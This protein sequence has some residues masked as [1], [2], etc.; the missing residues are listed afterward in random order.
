MISD[1]IGKDE[2]SSAFVYGVYGLF[3]KIANGIILF[4]LVQEFSKGK[5]ELAL[6]LIMGV[7]PLV[8]SISAF[9]LSILGTSLYSQRLA[10]LSMYPTKNKNMNGISINRMGNE[11]D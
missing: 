3:D 9:A 1:V 5:S 4:F 2:E 8:C 7:L 11:D 6:K 10:K